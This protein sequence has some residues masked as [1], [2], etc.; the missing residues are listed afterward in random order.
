MKNATAYEKKIRKLLKSMPK[1]HPASGGDDGDRIAVIMESILQADTSDKLAQRAMAAL[2]EE[3]VDFNELRVAQTKEIVECIGDDMYGAREKA[4]MVVKVLNGIFARRSAVSMEYMVDMT[5]RDLRRHL[6]ELGLDT[7]SA[8]RVVLYAFSGHAVPVDKSLAQCLEMEEMVHPDSEIEDVQGFLERIVS[9]KDAFAAHGMF[10]AFVAK[11]AKPLAKKRKIEQEAREKAEQ[12]ARKKAE[13][14]AKRAE[15]RAIKVAEKKKEAAEK[16]AE[17][18]KSAKKKTAKK[19]KVAKTKSAKKV[20]KKKTV[21]KASM[22]T[23]K[24]VVKKAAKK[25]AK[26]KVKKAAK[27]KAKKR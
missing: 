12:E 17:K 4:E 11:L 23:V 8:A 18:K 10:R 5:K 27:K 19:K 26:K 24:K 2:E 1:Q 9:Q 16:A 25:A 21:K 7:F 13:Q 3:F 15:K 20:V 22:K 14:A 6:L